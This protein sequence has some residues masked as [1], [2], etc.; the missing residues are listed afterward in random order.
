MKILTTK[1]SMSGILRAETDI[2]AVI[3][4]NGSRHEAWFHSE[5]PQPVLNMSHDDSKSYLIELIKNFKHH[6]EGDTNERLNVSRTVLP[7]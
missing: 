6:L 1:G 5:Y 7:F 3:M 2:G 4:Y